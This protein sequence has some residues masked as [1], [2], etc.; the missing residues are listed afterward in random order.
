MRK[1]QGTSHTLLTRR[2]I[3][4]VGITFAAWNL[5]AAVVLMWMYPTANDDVTPDSYKQMTTAQFANM[6]LGGDNGIVRL[7]ATA[8]SPWLGQKRVVYVMSANKSGVQLEIWADGQMY[9]ATVPN[10]KV[11]R[12]P[13]A[14][15]GYE[16][17]VSMTFDNKQIET[18]FVGTGYNYWRFITLQG[19]KHLQ[20][21]PGKTTDGNGFT[22]MDPGQ[23]VNDHLT[24]LVISY[25]KE[26][27]TWL[28]A[29]G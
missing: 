12:S 1:P 7:P 14:G 24:S 26:N 11:T 21:V 3:I 15:N 27:H 2:N 19:A 10:E 4:T 18:M 28:T 9:V 17:T 22:Y 13:Q 23:A 6:A 16:G 8:S 5:L 29:V 20:Y 25:P